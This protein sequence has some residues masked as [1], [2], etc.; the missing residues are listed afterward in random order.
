MDD[1]RRKWRFSQR[2]VIKKQDFEKNQHM[3]RKSSE[4]E[5]SSER[6][7]EGRR[8]EAQKRRTEEEE[9]KIK[10]RKDNIE[11]VDE[12]NDPQ[13]K[14]KDAY[15]V[16]ERRKE[17]EDDRHEEI[18]KVVRKKAIER[19][20]SRSMERKREKELKEKERD[21]KRRIKRVEH[22]ERGNRRSEERAPG[23]RREGEIEEAEERKGRKETERRTGESERYSREDD[24]RREQR[25]PKNEDAIDVACRWESKKRQRSGSSDN[26]NRKVQRNDRGG[27]DPMYEYDGERKQR[28]NFYGHG[29]SHHGRNNNY[30][31][32]FLRGGFSRGGRGH[33]NAGNV[34]HQGRGAHTNAGPSHLNNTQIL[35][36]SLIFFSNLDHEII[37][38]RVV[39]RSCLWCSELL[40]CRQNN[41]LSNHLR[42]GLCKELNKFFHITCEENLSY[43]CKFCA[44]VFIDFD[45]AAGHVL[46]DHSDKSVICN[47]C[48]ESIVL[49][50]YKLH[51][52]E[53][54]FFSLENTTFEC[55]KCDFL[56]QAH[57]FLQHIVDLHGY[58]L[59]IINRSHIEKFLVKKNSLELVFLMYN[60][61]TMLQK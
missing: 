8:E 38:S 52:L 17:K 55:K 35:R 44:I 14:G 7:E 54:H 60:K 50:Q 32:G 9:A 51:K 26:R 28:S 16:V 43:S 5:D 40:R 20:E 11:K 21:E 18:R 25:L 29:S 37:K 12:K 24:H 39:K 48:K 49:S 27:G 1:R 42:K 56:G 31:S 10:K 22:G 34:R 45:V 2:H 53:A 46:K 41:D 15:R 13:N 47:L 33:A 58:N 23:E 19:E 4:R 3:E 59:S 61:E 6:I 36:K 30:N 57:P